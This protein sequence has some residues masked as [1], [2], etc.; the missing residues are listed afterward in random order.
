MLI[1]ANVNAKGSIDMNHLNEVN[2]STN[3]CAGEIQI[4]NPSQE[5]MAISI[6][7]IFAGYINGKE[8]RFL[9]VPTGF[10]AIT[11]VSP[12]GKVNRWT[13]DIS[14]GGHFVCISKNK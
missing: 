3:S 10:H 8:N 6:N 11:A 13:V 12:S 5:R 2:F 7:G 1:L 14:C 9:E 4:I